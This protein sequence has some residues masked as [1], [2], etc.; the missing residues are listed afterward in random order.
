MAKSVARQWPHLRDELLGQSII[1]LYAAVERMDSIPPDKVEHYLCRSLRLNLQRY[2]WEYAVV[3]VPYKKGNTRVPVMEYNKEVSCR[4]NITLEFAEC[5]RLAALDNQ[6]KTFISLR[7]KGYKDKYIA[8]VLGVHVNVVRQIRQNT[9][10]RFKLL[11]QGKSAG[12]NDASVNCD[13]LMA[14]CV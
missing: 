14:Q 6:E 7:I 2:A 1:F 9:K 10:R 8:D 3:R 11:W 13:P 5:L 12:V 4:P